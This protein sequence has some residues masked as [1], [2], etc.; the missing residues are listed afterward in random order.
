[1]SKPKIQDP[2]IS[3]EYDFTRA[4]RGVHHEAASAG[5]R[6]VHVADA[7]DKAARDTAKDR[8]ADRR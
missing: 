8:S 2:D 3:E 1:M 7:E 6:I 5:I 4:K